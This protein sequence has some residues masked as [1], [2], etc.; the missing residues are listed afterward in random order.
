VYAAVVTFVLLKVLDVVMGLRVSSQ[1][2]DAGLDVDQHGESAYTM[3]SV[4]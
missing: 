1:G 3:E 2:E 4:A